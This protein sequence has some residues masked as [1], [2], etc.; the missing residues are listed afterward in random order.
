MQAAYLFW[1][2]D[3]PSDHV[4]S[5]ADVVIE[6]VGINGGAPFVVSG[7]DVNE[8]GFH[9][10]LLGASD[11]DATMGMD[12]GSTFLVLGHETLSNIRL[13]EA[14]ATYFG[15]DAQSRSGRSVSSHGDL[16]GDGFDDLLIGAPQYGDTH[17][18]SG[19]A[20]LVLGRATPA[21]QSLSE[22]DATWVGEAKDDQA[23]QAVAIVGDTNAD[24]LDDALIAAEWAG[25]GQGSAYLM[26]G[27]PAPTDTPLSAADAEYTTA[28]EDLQSLPG[29]APCCPVRPVRAGPGV[30]STSPRSTVSCDAPQ[31]SRTL[32]AELLHA[33]E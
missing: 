12:T 3:H 25:D 26:L 19:A 23:G 22:A 20:F 32:A 27:T 4:V 29:D 10:L 33:F 1:G 11:A 28:D 30:C 31:L 15:T 6:A 2:T 9:D 13:A 24:G 18:R 17:L 21:S 7:G 8:D 5:V 14:D 16:N